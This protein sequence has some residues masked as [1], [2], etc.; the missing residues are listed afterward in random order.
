M[1]LFPWIMCCSGPS[2]YNALSSLGSVCLFLEPLYIYN[3][4]MLSQMGIFRSSMLA[5][6][7]LATCEILYVILYSIISGPFWLLIFN[8]TVQYP[9]FLKLV[10]YLHTGHN[11]SSIDFHNSYHGLVTIILYMWSSRV[12]INMNNSKVCI[13]TWS[14]FICWN[15]CSSAYWPNKFVS[16]KHFA[17]AGHSVSEWKFN[18]FLFFLPNRE[19]Q[20]PSFT[21]PIF[22]KPIPLDD[23]SFW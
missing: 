15:E 21:S 4:C 10:L 5:S 18:K 6:W 16:C 22:P 17:W 19:N 11:T 9:F 13:S 12:K 8:S 7:L 14:T 23:Q 20:H 1:S 2:N 3:S